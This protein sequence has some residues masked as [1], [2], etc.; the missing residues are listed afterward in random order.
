[1]PRQAP[2]TQRRGNHFYF[3]IA[4]PAALSLAARV[5]RLINDLPPQMLNEKDKA[6]LVKIQ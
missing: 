4:V 5:K 3:R 1:M 6:A 2:C